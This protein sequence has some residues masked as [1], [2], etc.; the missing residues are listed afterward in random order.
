M[1]EG[2]ELTLHI[3]QQK[4]EGLTMH[5]PVA[6]GQKREGPN[7]HVHDMVEGGGATMYAHTQQ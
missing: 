1:I 7:V 4:G 3:T 6:T 5:I 2:E